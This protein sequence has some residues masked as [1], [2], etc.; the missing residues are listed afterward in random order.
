MDGVARVRDLCAELSVPSLSSYGL[1]ESD[2][3]TVVA[4]ARRSGSM[5]RDPAVLTTE[6]MTQIL[7]QAVEA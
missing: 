4:Q 6:E 7:T 2:F 5:Q 1:Q 3:V